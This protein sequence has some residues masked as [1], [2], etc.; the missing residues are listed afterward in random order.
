MIARTLRRIAA[1]LLLC[2]VRP[3]WSGAVF[4]SGDDSDDQDHCDESHCGRM[5][6]HVLNQLYNGCE[7][8]PTGT[9]ILHVGTNSNVARSALLGNDPLAPPP[10]VRSGWNSPSNGGPGACLF[11]CN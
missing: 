3:C 1:L 5:I 9:C 7:P 2:A 6:G 8:L 10:P 4:I 11:E